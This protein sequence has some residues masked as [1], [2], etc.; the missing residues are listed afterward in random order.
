MKP[1]HVF[2]PGLSFAQTCPIDDLSKPN[3]IDASFIDSYCAIKFSFLSNCAIFLKFLEIKPLEWA[4]FVFSDLVTH[5]KLSAELLFLS[6]S[7]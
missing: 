2:E 4:C 1:P 5:S 6:P 3:M 7:I